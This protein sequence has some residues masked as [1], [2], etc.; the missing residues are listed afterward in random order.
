MGQRLE[1]IR[2][3]RK[4]MTSSMLPSDKADQER[5]ALKKRILGVLLR[6]ARQNSGHSIEDA[7][8][9]LGISAATYRSFEMGTASPTLPQMEVLAYTFNVP[10]NQLWG[11]DTLAVKRQEKHI[12]ERIPTILALRDRIIGVRLRQLRE[13]AALTPAELAETTG[14]SA[15][16]IRDAERGRVSLPVSELEM[17][18]DALRGRVMDIAAEGHGPIGSWLQTQD[19][20]EQFANLPPDLRAFILKPINRSYL[21]LAVKLAETDVD[22]LRTIAESLLEITL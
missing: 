8:A 5:L 20:F 13:Q 21:E 9:M 16:R 14:V 4:R 2:R 12:R 7:A 6:D 10:L 22:R 19:D 11:A 3:L 18:V 1:D 15:R 17:L